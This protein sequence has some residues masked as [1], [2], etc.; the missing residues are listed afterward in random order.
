MISDKLIDLIL[1]GDKDKFRLIVEQYQQMVFQT[2]M[3]Y[4]HNKDDADDLTQEVF[5][6][7]Y[8][9]LSGF[10][11][12]SSISTWLYR[13]AINASLNKVRKNSKSFLLR[14]LDEIFRSEKDEIH[15]IDI[16]DDENPESII[17][18]EEHRVWV[19][20]ALDSL[21]ENQRTAIVLS[22]YDDLSQREIAEIMKTTEGAVE[23][24]IQRAKANLRVK[25]T[26][27]GK[28]RK[29]TVGKK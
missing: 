11:K 8:Q 6:Q 7:A 17:I 10:R 13:I 12:E 1:R 4:V 19:L 28:K 15:G 2:C 5:I 25:L 23:A 26:S 29:A 3:G 16:Y 20:K 21:P 24:L 22:K 9:A 27:G 14:H 18:R